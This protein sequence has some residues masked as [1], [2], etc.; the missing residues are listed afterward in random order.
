VDI[1][2]FKIVNN[3]INKNISTFNLQNQSSRY[4]N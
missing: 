2:V 1:F 4:R 3:L